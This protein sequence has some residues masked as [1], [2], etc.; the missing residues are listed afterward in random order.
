[1]IMMLDVALIRRQCFCFPVFTLA[2]LFLLMM[3]SDFLVFWLAIGGRC[4]ENLLNS[5]RERKILDLFFR[6]SLDRLTYISELVEEDFPL[7]SCS[8]A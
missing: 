8:H 3:V 5:I 6:K 2:L 4:C 1:M 7:T